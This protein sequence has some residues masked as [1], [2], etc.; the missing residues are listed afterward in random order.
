MADDAAKAAAEA[1]VGGRAIMSVSSFHKALGYLKPRVINGVLHR[2]PTVIIRGP[3]AIG[4]SS[5]VKAYAKRVLKLPLLD[6]RIGQMGEG[7]VGGL[8]AHEEF[9]VL[10]IDGTEHKVEGATAFK[11]VDWVMLAC[12]M[13]LVLFMDEPNRATKEVM[14]I[15]FQL[16]L[17]YELNGAVL[18]PESRIFM[19]MNDGAEYSVSRMD[20]AL[21]SRFWTCDLRPTTADWMEWAEDADSGVHQIVRDFHATTK[22]AFLDPPLKSD[23]ADV[24]ADRRNWHRLALSVGDLLQQANEHPLSKEDL[25]VMQVVAMGFIGPAAA[26]AFKDYVANFSQYITPDEIFNRWDPDKFKLT[27]FAQRTVIIKHLVEALQTHDLNNSDGQQQ[28]Q[29]VAELFEILTAEQRKAFFHKMTEQK[30]PVARSNLLK[31]LQK[32]RLF[33]RSNLEGLRGRV[34]DE[35]TL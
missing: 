4:K 32:N 33:S 2:P 29:N 21:R 17:D 30:S 11:P 13:P 19:A 14:Q 31:H 1:A 23:P 7:D 15:L 5:I 10:N 27:S 12:K 35:Q 18:H 22:F 20:P 9:S 24:V 34:G 3:H 26:S 25:N 16:A 28:T 8:P 6:R